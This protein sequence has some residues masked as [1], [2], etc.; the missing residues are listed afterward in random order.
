MGALLPPTRPVMMQVLTTVLSSDIP[1]YIALQSFIH[2][3]NLEP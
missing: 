2:G 3:K 1:G